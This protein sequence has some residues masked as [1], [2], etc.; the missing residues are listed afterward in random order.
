MLPAMTIK[1]LESTKPFREWQR[2]NRKDYLS[3]IVAISDDRGV[4][5]ISI[6]YYDAESDRITTFVMGKNIIIKPKAEIFKK[7]GKV[8]PLELSRAKL[9]LEKIVKEAEKAAR[10]NYEGAEASKVIS[11]LQNLGEGEVWNVTVM[12]AKFQVINI[13]IDPE[14]GKALS[15]EKVNLFE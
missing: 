4:I 6:G 7:E 3:H 8:K 2:K 13:R 12:T 10:D 15:H 11:I 14:T 5:E 1:K 9:S